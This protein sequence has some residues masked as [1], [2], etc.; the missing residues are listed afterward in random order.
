LRSLL[1]ISL[2]CWLSQTAAAQLLQQPDGFLDAVYPAGG[3]VGQTIKYE[4]IGHAGLAGAR[5]IV[6]EGPPGVTV[7]E[8][9]PKAHNL[10]EAT[11][12]IAADATPGRRLLR[13]NGGP[14]GLTNSRPF[15]VGRLPEPLEAEPNDSLDKPCDVL[16][17]A[18]VNARLDKP[19]DV[20]CFRFQGKQGQSIVAAVSAHG[21][22]AI[23]RK[24]F[25]L[26]FL[27]TSLEILSSS[28][29]VLAAAED[30]IS[31]D[32]LVHYTLPADG[33]Y[34][35]RVKAVAYQGAPSAVYRLSLG[36]LPYATSVFPSGGK[37][38]EAIELELSGPNIP[39]GTKRKV[40]IDA[41][42]F[43]L[44]DLVLEES[45]QRLSLVRGDLPELIE[46]EPNNSAAQVNSL[47]ANSTANGRFETEGDEDWYAVTLEKGQTVAFHTLAQRHLRAPVDTR[48]QVCDESGKQLAEN[49]DGGRFMQQAWHDF[50]SADSHL[51]FAAPA[52]GRYLVRVSN[53][54]GAF[55]KSS[56]YRLTCEPWQ[57]D[58][59]VFAWP[60]AVPIW[61]PGATASFVVQA[62]TWAGFDSDLE[63]R[64]E[65]LPS[66][67]QSGVSHL[68]T[69]YIRP[70]M[71]SPYGGQV[72]MTITAS[73]DAEIG[74]IAPFRVV[75][76]A[77][78]GEQVI[79]HE[80]QHLTLYGN[81]HN[82][83][84]FLRYSR[85]AQAV[86]ASPLDCR[87]ETDVKE[88]SVMQGASTEI[89]VR[90]IRQADSKANIGISIDGSTVAAGT[91]WR[92]P[93][94]LAGDQS[95][96]TIPFPLSPEWKPGTYTIVVSRSWAADIRSG[97]PGPC[98]PAIRLN[99][100]LP[101]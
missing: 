28:G 59:C 100:L 93:L 56:I 8:V 45:S 27:D 5:R 82:D 22:D 78:H 83:R 37:R 88:L 66:G 4:F 39:A 15:F 36:E 26:G 79:E 13:V 51:A 10:V 23:M 57:P 72:L 40:S 75:A 95:Q 19:L 25:I 29:Q 58:F 87:L 41:D 12:E 99:I 16:I 63:F 61:G 17:P 31:L 18:I 50:E 53:G 20:D 76:R 54:S 74:A 33:A 101:K 6:V 85:G 67:W 91:G 30:T 96:I 35:V 46:Q 47:T 70:F 71:N 48:L 64:V 77:K 24:S 89:P 80:A 69:A 73:S 42:R 38:G 43:L 2:L 44:Q 14:S 9:T 86:V 3:Q 65:G 92:A 68:P 21:I 98:T 1:T 62:F 7:K 90:V 11:L 49:D 34:I 60:D 84:M 32:P 81:S 55:G 94:A 97:R 52:A